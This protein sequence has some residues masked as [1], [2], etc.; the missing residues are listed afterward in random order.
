MQS[1]KVAILHESPFLKIFLTE[2]VIRLF[3]QIVN[4]PVALTVTFKIGLK[5]RILL[6]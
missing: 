1:F 6:E 5:R 2:V 4:R 3:K